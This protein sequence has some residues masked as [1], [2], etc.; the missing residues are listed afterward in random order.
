MIDLF[1]T[2]VNM[3]DFLFK[4]IESVIVLFGFGY[5]LKYNFFLQYNLFVM[6]L[7]FQTHVYDGVRVQFNMLVKDWF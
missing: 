7:N 4:L 6:Y 2:S 3:H 1:A 5:N